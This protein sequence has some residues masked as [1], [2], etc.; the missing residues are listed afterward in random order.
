MVAAYMDVLLFVF[1]GGTVI[2]VS[3]SHRIDYY[4]RDFLSSKADHNAISQLVLRR[5]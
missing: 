1:C 3:T 4:G 2:V 5:H